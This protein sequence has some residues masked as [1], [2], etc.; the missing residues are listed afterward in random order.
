MRHYS[1]TLALT[2][3]ARPHVRPW[4]LHIKCVYEHADGAV[5]GTISADSTGICSGEQ[6]LSA[7]TQFRALY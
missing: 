7:R 3:I 4:P 6:T 2:C 5:V 1:E